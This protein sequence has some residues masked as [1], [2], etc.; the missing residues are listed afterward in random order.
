MTV[1]NLLL[2][3][4]ISTN[5][6][7]SLYCFVV[8]VPEK[9]PYFVERTKNHMVPVYLQILDR[10]IGRRT[11]IRRVEGDLYKLADELVDYLKTQP[12]NDY[13][14]IGVKVEEIKRRISL[15]GDFVEYTKQ[16]LLDK[17]F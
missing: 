13:R 16:F 4:S 14:V 17:G 7:F 3:T 6:Y 10:G 12:R 2:R 15:R 11:L 5:L 9:L 8:A 1:T